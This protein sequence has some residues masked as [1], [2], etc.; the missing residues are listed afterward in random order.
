M[1]LATSNSFWRGVL[2]S[3]EGLGFHGIDEGSKVEILM[4]E[5]IGE[6]VEKF[7]DSLYEPE[8]FVHGKTNPSNI[9]LL[10]EPGED[11]QPVNLPQHGRK[12]F[13]G[14]SSLLG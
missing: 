7:V 3:L 14:D 12:D 2:K 6:E 9:F 1:V 11:E 10:D 5:L 8:R 4:L 13:V